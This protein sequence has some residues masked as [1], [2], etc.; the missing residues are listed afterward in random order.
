MSS[1][2]QKDGTARTLGRQDVKMLILVGGLALRLL[3]APHGWHPDDVPNFTRW[4]GALREHGLLAAYATSDANYPP[5]GLAIIGVP[6]WLYPGPFD[7][8][9]WLLALKMPAML[10]DLGIAWA[11]YRLARRS[12]GQRF[13]TL[14][15]AAVAFNPA[16][17]YLS[18]WWGQIESVYALA[19]CLAVLL[20]LEGRPAWAGLALGLGALVKL[21]AG[22]VAPV[23][24]IGLYRR[25]GARAALIGG[26]AACLVIGLGL[27]PYALT[28]QTRLV[29]ARLT[30]VVPGPGWPTVNA[31][32]LW[33]V[34]T[35]GR[36]NWAY[37]APLLLPDTTP[38]TGPL[39][40]RAVGRGLWLAWCALTLLGVW[41]GSRRDLARAA[42]LGAALLFVGFFVW[43]TK[44]HERYLFAA[45]PLLA[46]AWSAR[47][48]WQDGALYGILSLTHT[49]NLMWAAP[50][51]EALAGLAGRPE[52]GLPV[53]VVHLGLAL[54]GGWVLLAVARDAHPHA[55]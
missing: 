26:L 50:P 54:W 43:P 14:A 10:A 35:L 45:L 25:G 52:V 37:N 55:P 11:V 20:A 1:R 19:A 6:A 15:L 47:Q 42:T 3:I 29:W 4:A 32:N 33:Y 16:F 12:A 8:P 27:A 17:I 5:L 36:G 39:T 40:M 23:V 30:A 41:I 28:G 7:R 9:A 22:L 51:G 31:L 21:Q 2:G 53:A 44:V 49:F 24:L 18:A 13:A 38:L 48:E 34:A 46:A